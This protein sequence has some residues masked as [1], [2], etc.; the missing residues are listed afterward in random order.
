MKLKNFFLIITIFSTVLI[1]G[2]PVTAQLIL[3]TNLFLKTIPVTPTPNSTVTASALLTGSDIAGANYT[4]FLNNVRQS[5][6]GVGKN[7]FSFPTGNLGAVYT[8]SVTVGTALGESLRDS[9]SFTVSDADLTWNSLNEAPADYEG[10]V[11]PS[12]GSRVIASV[13]PIIFSPGTKTQLNPNNLSYSWFLDNIFDSKNSGPGKT[14]YKFQLNNPTALKVRAANAQ[15]TIALEKSVNLPV[16]SPEVFIFLADQNDGIIYKNAVNTL[17]VALGQKLN[18]SARPYFFNLIPLRLDWSWFV[19]SEKVNGA[20]QKPW[21][22]S[23]A[24]PSELATP[25]SINVTAQAFNPYQNGE[26]GSKNINIRV[27]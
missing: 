24:V 21:Q 22:A 3:P 8:V 7:T 26:T 13:L 6:S 5:D 25:T 10:K 15:N 20:P 23:L 11:L 17:G 12:K 19:N 14:T 9:I 27:K 4:W 1:L 16:V 2:D 18:F